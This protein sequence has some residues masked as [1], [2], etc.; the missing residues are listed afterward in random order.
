MSIL[1]IY[2][3]YQDEKCFYLI[4]EYCSGGDLFDAIKK[5]GTFDEYSASQIIYQILSAIFYCHSTNIVHRDIKADCIFI[6]SIESETV[7][8]GQQI[9]FYNI[10]LSDFSSARSFVKNK[11][12]TKKIGTPYYIAPEVL[13][14][15]YNEKCDVWS[16]GV[17]MFILLTGKPP[18]NGDT[19]REILNFVE[20]GAPD[21]RSNNIYKFF[22]V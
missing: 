10:R 4:S 1:K 9:E 12:L 8:S 3:F 15:N 11:K 2:E 21:K 20:K 5:K 19:E 6:E 14:R 17:L 7:E 13:K 22:N 16:I 18:F